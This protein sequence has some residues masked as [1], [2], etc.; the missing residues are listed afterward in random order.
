[1]ADETEIRQSSYIGFEL[2]VTSYIGRAQ[3][4]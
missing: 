3:Y 2:N 1:M 4:N